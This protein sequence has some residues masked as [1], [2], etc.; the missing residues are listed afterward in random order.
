LIGKERN[1]TTKRIFSAI[2]DIEESS[3]IQER[4]DKKVQ[5]KANQTPI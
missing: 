2:A 5:K 4:V 1:K 3:K